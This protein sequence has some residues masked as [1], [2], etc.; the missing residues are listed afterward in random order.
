MKVKKNLMA[1]TVDNPFAMSVG[2]LM[3][4]VLMVFILLLFGALISVVDPYEKKIKRAEDYMSLRDDLYNDLNKEFKED[5]V[6]WNAVINRV[7]LSIQFKEPDVLFGLGAST[8]KPQFRIILDDF[9]P[10]YLRLLRQPKYVHNIEEIRIEGHTSSDW[11]YNVNPETAYFLNMKLSQDRTRSVLEYVMV[12][13][14]P[15]SLDLSLWAKSRV[16]ANGLSSSKLMTDSLGNEDQVASR[17]VEFRIM[18]DALRQI[19]NIGGQ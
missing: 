19:E 3:A 10:R 5:L 16:T 13:L 9:F 12:T 11:R 2:D 14:N 8:V 4:G 17:R 18:T 6:R 7:T 15:D 1:E